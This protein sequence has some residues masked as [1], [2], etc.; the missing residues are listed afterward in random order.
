MNMKKVFLIL[1]L[2]LPH[3]F[4]A[5]KYTISGYIKDM[6]SG[7]KLYGTNI[8]D[9]KTK[10]GTTSNEYGFYSLTLDKDSVHIVVSYVGYAPFEKYIY[11]NS[12]IKLNIDL[13]SSIQ[14]AEVVVSD[15]KSDNLVK[16][17]QMGLIEMPIYQIKNLPILL[18][19]ADV[20]KTLQLMPGVQSGN[21]GS[22]GI[23][24]RGG[25]PDQN[26]ILL[27]GVPVYNA[28][29]LFGFFS[30]FNPDAISNVKLIKG[31]F[32]SHYGGRLSSVIDIRM[33]EGN[34]KKYQG[35]VSVGTVAAKLTVEGPIVKDKVSFIVSGRR[36]YIDVLAA[37]L[38]AAINN[39]MDSKSKTKAGYFFYDANAKINYNISD[40][41]KLYLSFYGGR[42][43]AYGKN[44][45]KYIYNDTT[46]TDI[47]DFGLLWGNL[48]GSLRWNHEYTNK[49]FSN[50]TLVTSN[51]LFNTW[52]E[53][54]HITHKTNTSSYGLNYFSG[55]DNVGGTIDF[56][57]MPLPHHKVKFGGNYLYHTFKPGISTV[58]IKEGVTSFNQKLGN[59]NIYA[60]EFYAYLED[61]WDITSLLKVNLGAHYSGFLVKKKFYNSLQPRLSA[62]LLLNE[63]MS[64]KIAYTHMQQY[65]HLLTNSTVGLP[66]DL[67]LP[68]T[69]SVPPEKSKQ[70][71]IGYTYNIDNN[72]DISFETY[73]KTLNNLIEY[74]EGASFFQLSSDWQSKLEIG[75]GNSYG[76]EVLLR[77]NLGKLTGWIGYTLSWSWRNFENINFGKPFPYKYDRRHDLSIVLLYKI[78]DNFDI[79]ATWVY[80]TGNSITLGVARYAAA[81]NVNS[82]VYYFP[83]I[84]YYSGRNAYKMPAYHRLDISLNLHKIKRWGTTSW[85]FGFYNAY[86]RQNPFFVYFSNDSN[87][88][89][90]L[91]QM[92]LF[93]IIPS[94]RYSVKF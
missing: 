23:Y 11:L 69:D 55:I 54:K 37:P 24:V 43:K 60:N 92:S 7:E 86:S 70:I 63:K 6:S 42:D 59:N 2:L 87:G 85:S 51:Y 32:P 94:V 22:S 68:S 30:V 76:F 83:E 18:G 31:G 40:K 34:M 15:R 38:V 89:R 10:K 50:L 33:K 25:G 3:F 39:K 81:A 49:L 35:E 72:W 28:T 77:K 91:K 90:V 80:G 29:H 13:S 4:F 56:D 44:E 16:S 57:Y 82:N 17:S 19:E 67:W 93:P 71:A 41:D 74:K 1:L 88:D 61:N 64:L 58:N 75:N 20:L 8:Y 65:I 78:N 84:E 53:F 26:L 27:D 66:T 45:S 9:L 46:N 48:T 62:R 14:L 52:T 36:T 79:G 12:D 73:Y 47:M 21:E 5:Q